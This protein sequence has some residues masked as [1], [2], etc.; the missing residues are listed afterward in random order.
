MPNRGPD[1]LEIL[2][3]KDEQIT[4]LT[5]KLGQ[6]HLLEQLKAKDEQIQILTKTI[7]NLNQTIEA[8]MAHQAY[9]AGRLQ[10]VSN[11]FHT[12][13]LEHN[14]CFFVV[15][16][17]NSHAEVNRNLQIEI[18]CLHDEVRVTQEDAD[19]SRARAKDW[20]E[21]NTTTTEGLFAEISRLNDTIDESRDKAKDLSNMLSHEKKRSSEM[22]RMCDKLSQDYCCLIMSSD[23]YQT[24]LKKLKKQ[25]HYQ[26]VELEA[27]L[28]QVRASKDKA[29]NGKTDFLESELLFARAEIANLNGKLKIAEKESKG[30]HEEVSSLTGQIVLLKEEAALLRSEVSSLTRQIVPVEME[31]EVLRKE[32]SNL[33]SQLVPLECEAEVMR[34]EISSLTGQVIPLERENKV[35]QGEVSNLTG[36]LV[37]REQG[38]DVMREEVSELTAQI[39]EHDCQEALSEENINKIE[40][41]EAAEGGDDGVHLVA[42][43]EDLSEREAWDNI[44]NGTSTGGVDEGAQTAAIDGKVTTRST[45]VKFGWFGC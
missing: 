19:Q 16:D 8:Q 30:L 15:G 29:S 26:I 23:D 43:S 45:V 4:F 44:S 18:E 7:G 1:L 3:K 2:R 24:E 27:E 37:P 14:Y 13:K 41:D 22:S 28:T 11:Q 5:T 32:V 9:T 6:P 12:L 10:D 39:V 42:T 40:N 38:A 31:S 21:Q 33:T 34:K 35:L 20:E 25:K 17:R 36:Q